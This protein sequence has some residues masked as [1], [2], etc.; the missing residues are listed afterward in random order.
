[1]TI[2][3]KSLSNSLSFPVFGLE[4]W[5]MGGDENKQPS[6]Q[7]DK[8]IKLIEEA[9]D[10]GFTHID[11]AEKYANGY[12]EELI[13]RAIKG[14]N[15][16]SIFLASKVAQ[17]NH[18]K[19]LL[20]HCLDGSLKRLNTD[21]LDLY[22]L[23]RRTPDTPLAETAEALNEAHQSGKIKNIGV[24]NFSK[25]SFDEL[26]KY[27]NSKI[28][29]NQVHY[30]LAFR[31]PETS[32][33]IEHATHHNYFIVAWRPLKLVKRNTSTPSVS[34]NIWQ[35]GAF[36]ILDKM[37]KK[38]NA[39][40]VEIAMAWVTYNPNV[41]TLVKSSQISHLKEAATGISIKLSEQDYQTLSRDFAPQ[42]A[43][44]DSIQLA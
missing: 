3:A 8:D 35:S 6:P 11:T 17:G 36:P 32:G 1:M 9:L 12:T 28:I 26:Q 5:M 44:S 40:N 37:A 24:C 33:L 21:Y 10:I 19:S 43:V 39:S 2:P 15:R 25:E 38:Y 42:Y 27:L 29:A 16:S 41:V 31:E 23:H 20:K 7:D 14:K 30:N 13:A 4:T 22:Y 18:T 34:K